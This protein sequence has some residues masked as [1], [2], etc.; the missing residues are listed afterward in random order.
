[1]QDYGID[2]CFDTLGTAVIAQAVQ[3]YFHARKVIDLGIADRLEKAEYLFG[4]IINK[5]KSVC[6]KGKGNVKLL[7][8]DIATL[9]RLMIVQRHTK[10]AFTDMAK[11]TPDNWTRIHRRFKKAYS[12][13]FARLTRM[14]RAAIRQRRECKQFFV[15]GNFSLFS[16]MQI[17][18]EE[19][20][21]KLDKKYENERTRKINIHRAKTIDEV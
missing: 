2:E 19:F 21:A 8:D 17:S 11:C 6:L 1:M 20:L 14:Q 5:S 4:K 15:D 12:E 10:E 16:S 9:M 3:D 7:E 18:G 13:G